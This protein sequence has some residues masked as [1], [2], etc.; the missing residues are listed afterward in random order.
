MRRGSCRLKRLSFGAGFTETV[1]GSEA[2]PFELLPGGAYVKI[3]TFTN[4]VPHRE[5]GGRGGYLFKA[6]RLC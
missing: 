1:I 4:L 6:V 2:A 3:K 5:A